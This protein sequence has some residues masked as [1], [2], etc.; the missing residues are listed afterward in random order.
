MVFKAA[1]P[2]GHNATT[3]GGRHVSALTAEAVNRSQTVLFPASGPSVLDAVLR[4]GV[5]SNFA[6]Q[7]AV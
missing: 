4:L 2:C 5:E 6:L 7:A 1:E 3:K